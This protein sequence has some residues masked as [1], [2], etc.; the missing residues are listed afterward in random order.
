MI[1]AIIIDDEE[2]A[3]RVMK[4]LL[5]EYCNDVEV[6]AVCRNIPD[7]VVKINNLDP[8][9]VFCD[10]DMPDYSGLELLSFFKEVTFELIFATGYSEFAVQAFEMSAIDYLLKP[11]QIE[12]L[13]KAI[14][15]LRA[16]MQK[17]SMNSRIKVLKEN[18]EQNEIHKV[19]LPVLDGL[20]FV[21]IK[22][23]SLMEADGAYTYV[24]FQDGTN[25]LVS[26]KLRY[27][28]VL[29]ENKKQFFRIHRSSIV[30]IIR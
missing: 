25:V 3:C 12:K 8:D 24:W 10:I 17:A 26:K 30:N 18:L 9:V 21:D 13:E 11:I 5:E 15:K 2:R 29:L 7:A 22:D 4:S 23:I 1:R 27:F 20:I 6:I 14:E 28:E 16:K 19:A